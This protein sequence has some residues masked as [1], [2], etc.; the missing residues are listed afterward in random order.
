MKRS[1]VSFCILILALTAWPLSV[2]AQYPY[3]KYDRLIEANAGHQASNPQIAVSGTKAVA[4]WVQETNGPGTHRVYSNYSTN[5]GATW[6]TAKLIEDNI[7][8]MAAEPQVVLSGSKAVAVWLQTIGSFHY[9]HANYSTDGG[10]TWHAD[11]QIESTGGSSAIELRCGMS[12]SNVV[13]VWLKVND[14]TDT[15][16]VFR[17]YSADGGATWG[18]ANQIETNTYYESK[19][20][21]VA[22]SGPNTVD[23]WIRSDGSNWRIFTSWSADGGFHWHTMQSLDDNAGYDAYNPKVAI[24]GTNAVAVWEQYTALGYWRIFSSYSTDGGQTWHPDKYVSNMVTLNQNQPQ[25]VLSGS[26]AVAIWLQTDAG[27]PTRVY[28][29]FSTDGGANWSIASP[30]E[31]NNGYSASAPQLALSGSGVAAVWTKS[32]GSASRVFANYSPNK[33]VTWRSARMV[34]GL[35]GTSSYT[36]QIALSGSAVVAVWRTFD[37][38]NSRIAANNATFTSTQKDKLKPPKLISPASGATGVSTG[39]SFQWQDM[40][41]LPQ[42]LK[43]KIRLKPAGGVY[44]YFTIPANYVSYFVSG[45]IRGKTYSWNVQ[46]VGNGT[47]VL[48]SS[49]GNGGVDWKFTTLP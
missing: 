49:W 41:S 27:N 28:S 18:A 42:E 38:S 33:G 30:I 20:P 10:A 26:N 39:V 5:G 19:Y 44:K 34:D 15:L 3:W 23:V 36:P 46:A 48:N 14:S 22:L 1:G 25:V 7:G 16:H 32:D 11:R 12:G 4:V 29:C 43:V 47:N 2:Q 13:A 8:S 40:N 24:S 6:H 17:N 21:H 37:G 9:V 31:T 45:L 35:G